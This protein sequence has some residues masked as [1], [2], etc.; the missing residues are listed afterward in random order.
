M[1]RYIV[2]VGIADSPN[3]LRLIIPWPSS[4]TV[5]SL[6]EEIV[7]RTRRHGR[8]VDLANHDYIFRLGAVDGP[9]LD[10]GDTLSDVIRGE[11]IF[12]RIDP[13]GKDLTVSILLERFIFYSSIRL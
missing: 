11:D 3:F 9:I 2:A 8:A 1:D 12:V 10:S 5:E 7:E 13:R 4:S 6:T